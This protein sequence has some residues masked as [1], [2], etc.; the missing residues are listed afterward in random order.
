MAAQGTDLQDMTPLVPAEPQRPLLRGVL[1][2]IGFV[3]AIVVGALLVLDSDGAR[4][5]IAAAVFAGSVVVMLGASALYHRVTWT[6]RVRPWMRRADHAGIYVLI[7]GSY[8]P[9]G[10]LVLHGSLQW[11][12]LA[13]VWSGAIAATILKFCWVGGPKWFSTG[14]AIGIGWIGIVALPQLLHA[15]GL[16]PVLLIAAGGIAYTLG[17]IVYAR[18][19]PDPVPF[20]FGYHELFHALTLV[21]LALQYVAFTFF[22]IGV[23]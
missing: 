13:L 1:H 14:I 22:V 23:T 18:R 10:L 12:V 3:A 4:H 17:G 21:A 8:T 6:P 2:L 9:V 19:K 16:V 7:A 5:V 15:V 20:V 11:V